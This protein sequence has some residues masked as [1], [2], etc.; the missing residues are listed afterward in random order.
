[1]VIIVPEP[2]E[3]GLAPAGKAKGQSAPGAAQ[4]LAPHRHSAECEPL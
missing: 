4:G 3:L 1:M 2:P